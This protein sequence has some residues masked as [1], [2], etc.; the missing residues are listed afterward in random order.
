VEAQRDALLPLLSNG[1]PRKLFIDRQCEAA[2]AAASPWRLR[3]GDRIELR[4][5]LETP[6]IMVVPAETLPDDRKKKKKKKIM[7]VH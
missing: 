4:Q 2:A 6:V 7:V 3:R 1:A 5:Q